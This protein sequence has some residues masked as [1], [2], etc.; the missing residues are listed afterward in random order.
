[1]VGGRPL[2][3]SRAKSSISA[4]DCGL[5]AVDRVAEADVL[6]RVAGTR[7]RSTKGSPEAGAAVAFLGTHLARGGIEEPGA[8][9]A[10]SG[11]PRWRR[12]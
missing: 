11:P 1:V 3:R 12:G 5:L 9:L 6:R 8:V 4:V 7:K 2:E 10:A